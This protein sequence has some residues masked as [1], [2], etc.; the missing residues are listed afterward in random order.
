MA[1]VPRL[2][3]IIKV[4]GSAIAF[5][6]SYLGLGKECFVGGNI[7]KRSKSLS[8]SLSFLWVLLLLSFC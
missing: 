7:G 3:C 6:G 2:S 1:W 5:R 4:E 8:D